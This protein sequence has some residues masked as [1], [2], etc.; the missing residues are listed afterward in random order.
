MIVPV[1]TMLVCGA[2]HGLSKAFL[3]WGMLHG[4]GL[5]VHSVWKR[6]GVTWLSES[7]RS[8]RVYSAVCWL[9]TQA[10]VAAAW[11]FFVPVDATFTVRMNLFFALFGIR[12]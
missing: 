6:K 12:R 10:F 5:G 9:G 3:V 4:A 8:H 11:I 2:W 7:L 1:A